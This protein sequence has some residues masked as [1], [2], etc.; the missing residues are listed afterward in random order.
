MSDEKKPIK[1][2]FKDDFKSPTLEIGH[3]EYR[4]SFDAKGQPFEVTGVTRTVKAKR[5]GEKDREVVV[6]SPE[7]ELA[8]L[9]D[10]GHFEVVEDGAQSKIQSAK[11][12]GSAVATPALQSAGKIGGSSADAEVRG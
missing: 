1:V 6:L 10:T 5:A 11:S 2:K 3:S 8:I 4:R 9:L 7:T 12:T